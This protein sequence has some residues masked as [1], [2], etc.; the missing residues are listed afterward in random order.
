M[1]AVDLQAILNYKCRDPK[2]KYGYNDNPEMEEEREKYKNMKIL[3][4]VSDAF[5]RH[6]DDFICAYQEQIRA[7]ARNQRLHYL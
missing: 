5:W 6:W 1:L 4:S 3:D 7:G 2:E